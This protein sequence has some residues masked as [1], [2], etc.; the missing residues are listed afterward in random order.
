[1]PPLN[2]VSLPY[3]NVTACSKAISEATG[4]P[5]AYIGMYHAN[6]LIISTY[7]YIS[8]LLCLYLLENSCNS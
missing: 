3:L 5:E 7:K 1:M 4:K 6:N 8:H 2:L